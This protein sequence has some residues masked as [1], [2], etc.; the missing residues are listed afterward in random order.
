MKHCLILSKSRK[1]FKAFYW[2]SQSHRVAPLLATLY[3]VGCVQQ[4]NEIETIQLKCEAI[5][6]VW[7]RNLEIYKGTDQQNPSIYKQITQKNS[8]N[9]MVQQNE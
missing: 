7:L 2:C 1:L 8:W 4:E 9:K 6:V 3:V 5:I